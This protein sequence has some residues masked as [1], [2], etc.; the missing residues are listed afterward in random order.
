M[1][2][3]RRFALLMA[4]CLLGSACAAPPAGPPPPEFRTTATVQDIMK[5]MVEPAADAIWNAVAVNVKSDGVETKAPETDD[6]WATVRHNAVMLLEATNL[7]LIE[8]RSLAAPGARSEN[9][10]AELQPEQIRALIDKDRASWVRLAHGLH[11]AAAVALKAID[12]RNAD[13]LSAS[14]EGIDTA[15]ESCHVTY[16]YPKKDAAPTSG[17]P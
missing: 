4:S 16:W 11:D 17:Q 6:E 5:S 12:A 15:C 9:P 8:G 10:E 2:P 7:I 13:A 3:C 1:S 14:G